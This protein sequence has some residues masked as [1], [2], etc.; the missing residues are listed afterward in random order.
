MDFMTSARK[1][2]TEQPAIAIIY[3]KKLY[4]FGNINHLSA[5]LTVLADIQ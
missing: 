1:S 5:F 4:R 3:R 2:D